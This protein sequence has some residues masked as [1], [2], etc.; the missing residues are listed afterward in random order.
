MSFFF[1]F[2]LLAR[3]C[4]GQDASACAALSDCNLQG[5]C[6]VD[7]ERGGVKCVCFHGYSGNQCKVGPEVLTSGV[8]V[9]G[10]V[11]G[12]SSKDY[13]IAEV[14]VGDELKLVA[15]TGGLVDLYYQVGRVSKI[16]A[17]GNT[18]S[19]QF[20][21]LANGK[22]TV[23]KTLAA[24]HLQAPFPDYPNAPYY[25]TIHNPNSGTN[26]DFGI[27]WTSIDLGPFG[28]GVGGY[29]LVGV[30]C[31]IPLGLAYYGYSKYSEAQKLKRTKKE[32]EFANMVAA[33]GAAAAGYGVGTPST[34]HLYGQQQQQQAQHAAVA[35]GYS[36][37]YDAGY[38]GYGGSYSGGSYSG[39]SFNGYP[40]Q[41]QQQQ[42]TQGWQ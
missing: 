28:L 42:Q 30:L 39:G 41:Q 14:N 37:N 13:Q 40:Q 8:E 18:S 38:E 5:K 12:L 25:V 17:T 4:F 36:A 23:R 7:T 24:K 15:K 29:I 35:Q 32:Q 1:L 19:I 34:N 31:L 9:V 22:S 27:T 16:D 11:S 20:R 10:S 6:V 3:P 2:F 26:A 33:G 21:F